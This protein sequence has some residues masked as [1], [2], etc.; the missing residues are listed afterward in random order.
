MEILIIITIAIIIFFFAFQTKKTIDINKL[1]FSPYP[2][3]ITK[4]IQSPN[5]SLDKAT[6]AKSLILQIIT[7]SEELKAFRS[8]DFDEIREGLSKLDPAESI[9]F[10]NGWIE[11]H[12]P[13]LEESIDKSIIETSSARYVFMLM[14]IAAT[15]VNPHGSLRDFLSRSQSIRRI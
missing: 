8:E 11:Q 7:I 2:I 6:L 13:T 1:C 10:V 14:L 5:D 12:L 4:Y 9:K 3:W 15:S